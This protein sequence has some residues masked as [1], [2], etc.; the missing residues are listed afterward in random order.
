MLNR[1]GV[2]L[3]K[4]G[5]LGRLGRLGLAGLAMAGLGLVS[6]Q[7]AGAP[8][9]P[10]AAPAVP[11]VRN[12]APVFGQLVSFPL[13]RGFVPVFE[14]TK[15]GFYIWEAVLAGET[16][17]K[18]SQMLTMTGMRGLAANP[19]AT[20]ESV[21]GNIVGGFQRTCPDTFIAMRLGIKQLNGQDAF[22]AVASCGVANPA[23]AKAAQH[24][25]AAM[26]IA[27][28]GEKNYYTLQWAERGAAKQL[29]T[30]IDAQTWVPRFR[31][32]E[33]ARL[34]AVV[35]GEAAPYPSCK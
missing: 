33:P 19:N 20:P 28:K 1:M 31:Q 11:V 2:A 17:D 24:S 15:D 8:K 26:V 34:C 23:S 35:V 5:R 14:E 3:V 7:E 6:A 4:W 32:L 27:I 18:W 30:A 12:I 16:V 21:V 9:A 22:G 10:A 13:P 29:K 25:E